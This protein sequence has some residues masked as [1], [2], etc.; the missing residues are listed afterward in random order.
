MNGHTT[1][2]APILTS[3]L[4]LEASASF[5]IFHICGNDI[6][7]GQRIRIVGLTHPT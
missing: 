7:A 5:R 1:V 4:A 6:G 2:V 3:T